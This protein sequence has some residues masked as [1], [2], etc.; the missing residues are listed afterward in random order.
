MENSEDRPPV[1]SSWRKWYLLVLGALALQII[2]YFWLTQAF[3]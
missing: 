3:A 2:L 1:F